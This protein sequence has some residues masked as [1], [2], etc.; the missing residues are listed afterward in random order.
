MAKVGGPRTVEAAA[1]TLN[2]AANIPQLAEP[3]AV[4]TAAS[5]EEVM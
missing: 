4:A 5:E 2:D 1:A 3:F